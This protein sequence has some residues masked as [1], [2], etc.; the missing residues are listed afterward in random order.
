MRQGGQQWIGFGLRRWLWLGGSIGRVVRLLCR[1]RTTV[2]RQI[3]QL[4]LLAP[5]CAAA[6]PP[7]LAASPSEAFGMGRW[8]VEASYVVARARETAVFM[9]ARAGAAAFRI[10]SAMLDIAVAATSRVS[11]RASPVM[12][13][14]GC[15]ACRAAHEVH[16][17]T[18]STS[19]SLP[20]AAELAVSVVAVHFSQKT[21]P[22]MRQ[23]CRRLNTVKASLHRW[24]CG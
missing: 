13:R 17:R 22:Q 2:L 10:R 20:S 19:P 24:H 21:R 3:D 12:P 11:V 8:P 16:T 7:P 1:L 23:W 18:R 14:I 4:A 15:A 5:A 9:C 6:S